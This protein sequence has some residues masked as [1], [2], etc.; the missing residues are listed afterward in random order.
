MIVAQALLI[1]PII[2][3]LTRQT[4]EDLWVEYREER[5]RCASRR[6]AVSRR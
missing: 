2:A 1:M 3:A 6:R 4:I 5:P